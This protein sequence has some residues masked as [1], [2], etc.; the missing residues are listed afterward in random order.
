MINHNRIYPWVL[1]V[2]AVVAALSSALLFFLAHATAEGSLGIKLPAEWS[3]PWAAAINLRFSSARFIGLL[4]I[5]RRQ[6]RVGY[7]YLS[8]TNFATANNCK[9]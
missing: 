6:R 3:L 1:A 7:R 5:R 2:L 8:F 4:S 9:L